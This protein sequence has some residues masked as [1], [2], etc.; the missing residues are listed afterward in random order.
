MQRIAEL[1]LMALI[2][3]MVIC[4]VESE[5]FGMFRLQSLLFTVNQ[6]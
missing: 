4:G 6:N 2:A 3:W 1:H 5:I